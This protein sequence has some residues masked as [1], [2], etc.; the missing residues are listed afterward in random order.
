[1]INIEGY[2]LTFQAIE[3]VRK[4]LEVAEGDIEKSKVL[5]RLTSLYASLDVHSL[6]NLMAE[7]QKIERIKKKAA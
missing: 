6:A 5:T 7:I 1:M 4:E 3:D 2:R